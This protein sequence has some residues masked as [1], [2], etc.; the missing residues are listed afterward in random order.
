MLPRPEIRM[1]LSSSNRK[2]KK[3][4]AYLVLLHAAKTLPQK[5]LHFSEFIKK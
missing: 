1:Q 2:L 5:M 4:F 3:P